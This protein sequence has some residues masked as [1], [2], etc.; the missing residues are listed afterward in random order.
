MDIRQRHHNARMK[1]KG[2]RR[3]RKTILA[4]WPSY[5]ISTERRSIAD[6]EGSRGCPFHLSKYPKRKGRREANDEV[7]AGLP[8][9][10]ADTKVTG[11]KSP[12]KL[13]R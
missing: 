7:I 10:E 1:L 4:C 8:T 2:L 5:F 3:R 9:G 11:L 13:A 6:G 12:G